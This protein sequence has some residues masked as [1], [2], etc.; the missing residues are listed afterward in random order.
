MLKLAV[1]FKW[2]NQ[3]IIWL[4]KEFVLNDLDLISVYS[5]ILSTKYKYNI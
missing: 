5:I 2:P 4:I 3:Q 1:D